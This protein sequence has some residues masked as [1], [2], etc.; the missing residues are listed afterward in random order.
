MIGLGNI[1]W[2]VNE[3]ESAALGQVRTAAILTIVTAILGLF[4]I[5]GWINGIINFIAFVMMLVGFNTLKKS[6]T[7]PLKASPGFNQLL[8]GMLLTSIASG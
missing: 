3:K 1:R 8:H 6:E 7:M 2:S 4:S 5:P